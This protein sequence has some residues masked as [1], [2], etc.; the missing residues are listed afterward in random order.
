MRCAAV[1]SSC[2]TENFKSFLLDGNEVVA[3]AQVEKIFSY[4]PRNLKVAENRGKLFFSR[5]FCEKEPR[6]FRTLH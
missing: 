3:I 4:A 5:S 6:I 1:E 2:E